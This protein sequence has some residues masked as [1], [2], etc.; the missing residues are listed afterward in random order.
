MK[1]VINV[2]PFVL[3]PLMSGGLLAQQRPQP[4]YYPDAPP[5]V[6]R[7]EPDGPSLVREVSAS[8]ARAKAKYAVFL[9][10]PNHEAHD[11][12]NLEITRAR[13]AGDSVFTK[14]NW[15]EVIYDR[16]FSKH[17]A[18]WQREASIRPPASGSD[19]PP[20]AEPEAVINFPN[21]V[22][23]I[24]VDGN[25]WKGTVHQYKE[26][27]IS[28]TT[29]VTAYQVRW[30]SVDR[31]SPETKGWLGLGTEADR[32][33]FLTAVQQAKEEEIVRA[34]IE[35]KMMELRIRDRHNRE[36][37]AIARERMAQ[38]AADR[39]ALLQMDKKKSRE[40]RR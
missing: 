24:I 6:E 37:E 18:R 17:K 36:M 14:S 16:V 21:S 8:K 9:A 40:S 28:V 22:G 23:N 19:A 3:M 26:G 1:N 10:D 12:I 34:E 32:Q 5:E 35:R 33:A 4:T 29:D 38:E 2:L 30:I 15:P 11:Q 39:A 20:A 31:L 25:V 7:S 13:K 27:K